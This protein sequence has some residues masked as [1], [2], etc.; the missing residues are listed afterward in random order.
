MIE[1]INIVKENPEGI[2]IALGFAVLYL[3]LKS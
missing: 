2:Y 1:I 3:I